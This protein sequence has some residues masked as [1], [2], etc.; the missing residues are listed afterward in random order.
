MTTPIIPPKGSKPKRERPQASRA[1]MI[2]WGVAL[3]VIVG[4][5]VAIF[6][7]RWAFGLT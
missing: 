7:Y 5:P 2:A 1:G 3:A 6:L 4:G